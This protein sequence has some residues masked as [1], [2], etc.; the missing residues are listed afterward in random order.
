MHCPEDELR[1]GKRCM[2]VLESIAWL[3]NSN[4]IEIEIGEQRKIQYSHYDNHNMS[5]IKLN[6]FVNNVHITFSVIMNLMLLFD[7][8]SIFL[9]SQALA[10][11]GIQELHVN[12]ETTEKIT[13][14]AHLMNCSAPVDILFLLDG[15]YSIGKGNFERSKYF[16][17]KLCDALDISPEKVRVGAIQ[18]SNTPFLEFSLDTYFTKQEIKSKLKKI[19]FKYYPITRIDLH[20][21]ILL[22]PTTQG[23]CL[24]VANMNTAHSRSTQKAFQSFLCFSNMNEQGP[25]SEYNL[26]QNCAC[27]SITLEIS[28]VHLKGCVSGQPAI[29]TRVPRP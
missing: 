24:V 21:Y 25:E 12:Q 14:A 28:V 26:M 29:K 22:V 8:I 9:F 5:S 7:S 10:S 6:N 17:I 18:F 4:G 19:V 13:A 16:T 3:G 27:F 20:W 11:W 23:D 2:I 1:E 15:S